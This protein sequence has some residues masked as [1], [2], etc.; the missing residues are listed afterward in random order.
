MACSIIPV[1]T[2]KDPI[3]VSI[4]IR[5]VGPKGSCPPRMKSCRNF[6]PIRTPVDIII[7]PGTE[8]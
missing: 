5:S 2:I 1:N 6:N 3:I 4:T 7:M 8:K